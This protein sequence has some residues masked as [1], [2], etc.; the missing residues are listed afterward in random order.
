MKHS[1]YAT[2]LR[3]CEAPAKAGDSICQDMLGVLYSEGHGVARDQATAFHW[4]QLAAAQGNPTAEFNLALAYERG[5][6]IAK[7]PAEAEK[8]YVKAAESG[9][10]YAQLHLAVAAVGG[11]DWKAA[12]KWLRP[13]AAQGLPPAQTMLG[14]AYE[15]GKGVR[16]NEKLAAKWYE[17]AADHGDPAAQSKLAVLYEQG[18]GVDQDFKESYFWYAVALRDP[19]NPTPKQD[20]EGLKRVA[21][22]L[23]A[24]DVADAAQIAKGWKPDEEV[25]GRQPKR[26]SASS[27]SRGGPKL[28]A[29]G[30]GFY[31]ARGGALITN[32]HVVADCDAVRISDG[33]DGIPVKVIAVDPQRDLALLQAPQPVDAAAVFRADKDRLGENIVVVGFPLS[34]LLSSQPIVT[35]GI[36]S[37]LAGM[38]DNQHEMQISAPIQPG[39]SGGPLFDSSGRITGVVVA[40]LDTVRLARAIGVVPENVNFAIKGDEAQ[41][42]LGAH[43][44][45]VATAEGGKELSTA[46]IAEQAVKMTVRL[47]CWK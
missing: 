46:A 6:G 19:K 44:V 29:T 2:V 17:A 9:L 40:T 24:A 37:A 1:D 27:R 8:W 22:K 18:I 45:K 16:R 47:E 11:G 28:F 10:P 21:A 32:N 12:I 30:T 38:R 15:A 5:E 13:A 42:F 23:S 35:S 4:F 26:R 3:V 36:I 33:H 14:L 31:V 7:N 43:G 20:A 39:N 41:Q 25:I 34:G